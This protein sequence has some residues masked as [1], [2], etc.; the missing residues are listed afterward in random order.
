MRTATSTVDAQEIE[1][2]SRLAD[3]WWDPRGP[4]APLHKINPLRVGYIRDKIV[5]HFKTL[6]G[7]QLLDIGCGAGLVCEPL[8]RLGAT[9]TGIDASVKNIMAAKTHA[10]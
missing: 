9:V 8:T 6:A 3:T 2:F 4:M 10:E 7:I 1:R 5:E